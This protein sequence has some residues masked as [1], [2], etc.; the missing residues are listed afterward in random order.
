MRPIK[1]LLLWIVITC[2]FAACRKPYDPPETAT[3]YAYLVVEGVINSG[4]DSTTITLSRTVPLGGASTYR[5]ETGAKVFVVSD[6]NAQYPLTESQPGTYVTAGLDLPPANKYSLHIITASG[7]IYESD[8][9][10]NQITPPIDTI[11]HTFNS[12]SVQFYVSA[13]DPTNNTRYYRWEYHEYWSYHSPFY[14]VLQYQNGA[15][16][17][18]P[19]DS[20][21]YHC[22]KNATP[23][24]GIF[25]AASKLSQGTISQEP[26][27]YVEGLSQKLTGE[28]AVE[29]KQYAITGDAY[30]YWQQLKTNTE[31]LG[32]IFDAQPSSTLTNIHCVSMPSESVIGFVSVS[33]S[34][35]KRAFLTEAEVPFR[36]FLNPG[37]TPPPEAWLGLDT[38][39]CPLSHVLFV[40]DSTLS[41]RL[42]QIFSPGQYA[43][44]GFY[45]N[46]PTLIVG[47]NYTP[48]AC[49]DCRK[50]GG[51]NQKPSWWPWPY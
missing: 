18:L 49:V 36:V 50:L 29:I 11:T 33:T 41:Q 2:A 43:T 35:L 7:K 5:P 17:G 30:S 31:E 10:E 16:V 23:P 15:I 14:T 32:T 40:P 46:P 28:Y 4:A 21:Y 3:D 45:Y 1:N 34:T 25:V 48:V 20:D 39:S 42:Q 44:P 38:L 8:F 22:Y 26:I 6:Q 37:E 47:Y 24:N 51:S 12:H 13:H 9:V 19:V 27:T